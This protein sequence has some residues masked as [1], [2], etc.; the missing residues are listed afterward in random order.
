MNCL[1]KS[2]IAAKVEA[3]AGTGAKTGAVTR[4]RPRMGLRDRAGEVFPE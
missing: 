4:V 2:W 1:N 3:G